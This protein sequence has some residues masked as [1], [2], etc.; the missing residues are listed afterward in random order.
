M[1]K[2]LQT[3]AARRAADEARL[4][5]A[6]QRSEQQQQQVQES[7]QVSSHWPGELDLPMLCFNSTSNK[8]ALHRPMSVNSSGL[9]STPGFKFAA[10]S[11]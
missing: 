4:H 2:P 5:A 10:S 3:S 7:S 9:S 6:K 11:S 1:K 8:L